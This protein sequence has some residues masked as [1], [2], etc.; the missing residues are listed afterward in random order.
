[1]N[2]ITCEFSGSQQSRLETKSNFGSTRNT[3][4]VIKEIENLD[5]EILHLQKNLMQAL[6]NS[7][8]GE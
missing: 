2:F 8:Q 1:M 6:M 7:S 5:E 4:G 3:K